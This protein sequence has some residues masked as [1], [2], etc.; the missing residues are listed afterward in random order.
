MLSARRE[1]M[2]QALEELAGREAMHR[3]L[4]ENIWDGAVYCSTSGEPDD[5]LGDWKTY[6]LAYLLGRS[7]VGIRTEDVLACSRWAAHYETAT[8]RQ[9]HLVGVGT[10]GVAALHAAALEPQLF[11]SLKLRNTIESWSSIVAERVPQNQLTSTV[12]GALQQYD[13]PNLIES[14]GREKVTVETLSQ[15]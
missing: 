7:L 5:V 8:P 15:R 2:G 10:A 12:H 9:V 11:A 4:F 6:Y 3:F 1:A 13:L 14:F